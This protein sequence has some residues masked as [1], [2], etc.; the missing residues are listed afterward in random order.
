M[1]HMV[2]LLLNAA[3]LVIIFSLCLAS[4]VSE[5]KRRKVYEEYRNLKNRKQ[6]LSE[7]E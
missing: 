2:W 6:K 3:I 1:K 7:G 4:E 5:E